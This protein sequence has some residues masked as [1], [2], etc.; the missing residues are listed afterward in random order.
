M[1]LLVYSRAEAERDPTLSS[2]KH[3][4]DLDAKDQAPQDITA[5]LKSSVSS[6][7]YLS[8]I[9]P[10]FAYMKLTEVAQRASSMNAHWRP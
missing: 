8:L 3:R 4:V 9:E 10:M 2:V 5:C 6:P 7:V 1:L